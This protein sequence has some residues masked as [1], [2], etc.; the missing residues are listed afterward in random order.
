MGNSE[1]VAGI[2]L[3]SGTSLDGL[4]MAYCEF[5]VSEDR[6]DFKIACAETIN[7]SDDWKNELTFDPNVSAYDLKKLDLKFGSW[8]GLQVNE[9][10]NTHQLKPSFI[11][12]HGH[13]WFHEPENRINL[14]IGDGYEIYR[15]TRIPV[16]NDFRSLDIRMGGQGAPLVPIGDELL[17]PAYDC[18]VNLGGFANISGKAGGKR[19]SFDVM[20][21]NLLLNFCS[22]KLGL[23][24]DAG[25]EMASS[26]KLISALKSDLEKLKYFSDS[27]PK[28]LG[29]EWLHREVFPILESYKGE[30]IADLLYTYTLFSA[31]QLLQ[32]FDVF[33]RYRTVLLTGGGAY[34][35]YFVE[36]L[37]LM[38]G[39]RTKI[40][41]PDPGVI[42]FK[43]AMV[44]AF[45]GLLRLDNKINC[46]NQVTG[47][48]KS[49]SG[50][51]IYDQFIS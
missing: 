24:F 46:L 51:I 3:M 14:Q 30:K 39:D 38:S 17:F 15:L 13:T 35:Q 26:G 37:K 49:V 50:G 19:I 5:Y 2:G 29:V 42:D 45:L 6:Y 4:D 1:K 25:G 43:E 44:F 33:D 23:A 27:P 9:F 48:S 41:L 32:S 36:Q 40:I 11:A 16:I 34:N 47:A 8:I 31:E 7:Y 20:P 18:C 12:S 28:S 22:R 10:I 21:F